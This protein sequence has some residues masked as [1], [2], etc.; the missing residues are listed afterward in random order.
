MKKLLVV[1]I[2][3]FSLS[4][5]ASEKEILQAMQSEIGRAMKDL[6]MEGMDVPYFISLRL[7]DATT[8]SLT[9]A[10]GAQ[11]ERSERRTRFAEASVRVG[12]PALD[13]TNFRGEPDFGVFMFS[14]PDLPFE[15]DVPALRQ[16]FWLLIDKAYKDGLEQL[17]KKKGFLEKHPQEEYPADF[18]PMSERTE[19]ERPAPSPAA[20]DAAELLVRQVSGDLRR[21]PFLTEGLVRLTLGR[22][23][24][25]Y[26]DSEG[27]RH[28]RP[29][30]RIILRVDVKA[31]TQD[32]YPLGDGLE[33]TGEAVE[34]LGAIDQI[35]K[36]VDLRMKAFQQ[37][38][39][40]KPLE[41]Y[42]GPVVFAGEAAGR[43]FYELLGKGVSSPREPLSAQEEMFFNPFESGGGFL[44]KR[45]GQKILPASFEVWD[46]PN[47]STYDGRTLAG[48]LPVDDEGMKARDIQI[49]AQGKLT[50][51]PM[52]RTATKKFTQV[53]G[54]ARGALGMNPFQSIDATVTNLFVGDQAGLDENAFRARIKQLAEEQ[55]RQDVLVVRALKNPSGDQPED[56]MFFFGGGGGAPGRLSPPV[57][58]ELL[59]AGTGETRPVWG[60]EFVNVNES[61]LNDI[62]ASTQERSL[63]QFPST[64]PF[65]AGAAA[66]V[67]APDILV[68]ELTL[69]KIKV[70]RRRPPALEMPALEASGK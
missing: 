16:A 11:V 63:S 52:R 5:T 35:R 62:A 48:F 2:L 34:E 10:F 49:I 20:F 38:L 23:S 39:S 44:A 60:L 13:Q 54:H 27:N 9:S 21:H 57:R 68:E 18:L 17:S 8:R 14:S 42:T 51:L 45:F 4:L 56:V 30:Q 58:M 7:Q 53:N 1:F 66:S 24:Q 41:D 19:W 55:G 26:L 29:E 64:S 33:W 31:F 37:L 25:L 40:Q 67:V 36:D 61:A 15:D 69:Q 70:Q 65:G 28:A 46:K 47:E 3:A 12:S 22:N 43:F 59:A 50:A 6:R 32:G